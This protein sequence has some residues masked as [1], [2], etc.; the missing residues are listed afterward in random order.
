MSATSAPR[1]KRAKFHGPYPAHPFAELFPLHDGPPL[2]ELREDIKENGQEERILLWTDPGGKVWLLD[3]RRRETCCLYLKLAPKYVMLKGTEDRMLRKVISLNLKRRHLGSGERSMVGGNIVKLCRGSNQHAAVE[4]T[5]LKL[6]P[7]IHHQDGDVSAPEAPEC[8]QSGAEKHENTNESGNEDGT[9][10]PSSPG[11]VSPEEAL[12]TAA[13][14]AE[15][16]DVSVKSIQRARTV[17]EKGTDALKAAASA[18]QVSVK[19]AA[20][21]TKHQAAVQDAAVA[22]VLDGTQKTLAKALKAIL[23]PKPPKATGGGTVAAPAVTPAPSS[24]NDE[25][26]RDMAAPVVEP[27][28]ETVEE[29]MK[30]VNGTIEA[31]CRALLKFATDTMPTDIWIDDMGRG[32]GAIREVKAACE[33]MRSAKCHKVC[34]ACKGDGCDQCRKS[35]RVPSVN[36]NMLKS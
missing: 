11:D 17:V 19:D 30:R 18:G 3:G 14:A 8:A 23:P 2:W 6:Y 36:Y 29:V 26:E 4:K 5:T 12:V 28:E 34:P 15:M 31:Y 25:V 9:R 32:A 10:V 7:P 1:P 35:G 20:A 27:K 21:A 33:S 22:L 13:K 16:M 24:L